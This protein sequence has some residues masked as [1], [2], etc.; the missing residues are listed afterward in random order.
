MIEPSRLSS[1][2][3]LGVIS[4]V[5]VSSAIEEDRFR[6]RRD[7]SR[8]STSRVFSGLEGRSTWIPRELMALARGLDS[9]VD[10]RGALSL[11]MRHESLPACCETVEGGLSTGRFDIG[12]ENMLDGPATS[13]GKRAYGSKVGDGYATGGRSEGKAWAKRWEYGGVEWRS[14]S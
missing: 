8:G 9:A 6:F 11:R 4:S 12:G 1:S 7:D 13:D 3:M 10:A 2:N 5:R 14:C